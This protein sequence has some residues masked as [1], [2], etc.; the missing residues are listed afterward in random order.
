MRK[1]ETIKNASL[2]LHGESFI[3]LRGCGYERLVAPE[4]IIQRDTLNNEIQ[5]IVKNPEL[6]WPMASKN[7]IPVV[8]LGLTLTGSSVA[9]LIP[10][11]S[12]PSYAINIEIDSQLI[13]NKK[14]LYLKCEYCDGTGEIEQ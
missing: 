5:K 13:L 2:S 4:I 11:V 9:S 3:E 12:P 1:Y 6:V 8:F 14:T 7:W 10:I